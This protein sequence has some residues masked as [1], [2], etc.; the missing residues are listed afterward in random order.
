MDYIDPLEQ[1][2]YWR[3]VWNVLTHD[4]PFAIALAAVLIGIA[5]LTWLPQAPDSAD[6]FALNQWRAKPSCGRERA[7]PCSTG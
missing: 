7:L 3:A 4:A 1:R 6:A 5:A 2:D